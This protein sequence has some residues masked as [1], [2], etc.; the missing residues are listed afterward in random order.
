ML[1]A[2]QSADKTTVVNS[3]SLSKVTDVAV[4]LGS[5]KL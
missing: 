5:A 1:I 2:V 3:V 4:K